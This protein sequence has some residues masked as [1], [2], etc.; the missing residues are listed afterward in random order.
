MY[1]VYQQ[2]APGA[3]AETPSGP[4]AGEITCAAAVNACPPSDAGLVTLHGALKVCR[5]WLNDLPAKD[6]T[7]SS[8]LHL[9]ALIENLISTESTCGMAMSNVRALLCTNC[10]ILQAV[11]KR[12][13]GTSLERCLLIKEIT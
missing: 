13:A 10:R 4:G 11:K 12:C 8:V 9:E 2:T 3:T 1:S 7:R 5:S 6:T